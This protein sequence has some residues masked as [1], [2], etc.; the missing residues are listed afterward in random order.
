MI[1]YIK[2]ALALLQIVRWI[3]TKVDRAQWKAEGRAEVLTE[4][5]A[6]IAKDAGVVKDVSDRIGKMSDAD[7]DAE[8]GGEF[9]P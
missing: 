7:I 8:F 3:M 1:S 6:L 5:L 4:Q 2:L 9:R